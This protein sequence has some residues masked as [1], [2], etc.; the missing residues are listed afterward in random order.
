MGRKLLMMLD[1][2]LLACGWKEWTPR[3]TGPQEA[4]E[5]S[6]FLES[7]ICGLEDGIF[8]DLKHLQT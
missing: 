5:A 7:K 2:T 3:L 8:L 1:V 6:E 4:S